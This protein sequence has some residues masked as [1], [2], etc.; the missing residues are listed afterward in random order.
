MKLPVS[1]RTI[2]LY[3]ISLSLPCQS[4][5]AREWTSAADGKKI[6]AEFISSD[7]TNV[8]IKRG[9]QAFTLPIARFVEAD[10]AFVKEQMAKSS[11]PKPLEGPY[12]DKFTGDWALAEHDGLP[13]AIYGAKDLDGTKKYPLILSLPGKSDNNTNGGQVGFSSVFSNAE[14]YTKNPCVIIAPLCYQPF[15]A[16]GGG[17][18]DEP[19]TKA[20]DLIAD[21]IKTCPVVDPNRVYV[22]GYSMGGFGTSFMV[23]TEPNRFA[24]AIPVAGCTSSSAAALKKMPVWIFHAADDATVNVS[25][26]RDLYEAIKRN[27]DA[28]YKEFETGGHGIIGQVFTDPEVRDW[29]FSQSKEK[30]K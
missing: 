21:V 14:S 23:E 10:Q 6:E 4:V 7:G 2:P 25:C 8:T 18:S 24:A 1:L 30:K 16:T 9:S 20:L 19:G 11:E 26:S 13:Y 5:D 29:L 28:K 12:T 22:I 15:G 27:D 17:W 3:L